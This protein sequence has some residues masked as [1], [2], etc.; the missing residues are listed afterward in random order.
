MIHIPLTVYGKTQSYTWDTWVWSQEQ[1]ADSTL[2]YAGR[3]ELVKSVLQG[4][5]CFWLSIIPIPAGV[6]AK[7]DQLCRNFLWGGKCNEYKQPLVAWKD[8]TLP[9]SEGG[10][11]LRNT[12]AWNKALLSKTLWNIHSKK[13][14]LWVQWVHQIYLKQASLWAYR[15]KPEDPPLLKQIMAIRDN[16]ISTEGT[17]QSVIQKISGL[18]MVNL[19]LS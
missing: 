6:R 11:G 3:T 8:V 14:S 2:S 5:K 10:L 16:L 12:K 7:I 17:A 13:D 9:K 15:T 1:V 18:Q 19:N 4:V